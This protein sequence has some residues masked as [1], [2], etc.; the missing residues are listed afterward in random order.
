[1]QGKRI[2]DV[3]KGGWLSVEKI[4]VGMSIFPKGMNIPNMCE[5]T[6]QF[7]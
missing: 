3:E 4:S 5:T 1:M 6:T 7:W 2:G